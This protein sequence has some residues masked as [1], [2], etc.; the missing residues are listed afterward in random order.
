MKIEL[1]DALVRE[2]VSAVREGIELAERVAAGPMAPEEAV[3]LML[4]F[5]EL[6]DKRDVI[7]ERLFS[8]ILDG[9]GIDQTRIAACKEALLGVAKKKQV[10]PYA[11]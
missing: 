6:I 4:R 8:A 5:A 7:G 10:D 9:I 2:Y 3:K 1:D 11:N